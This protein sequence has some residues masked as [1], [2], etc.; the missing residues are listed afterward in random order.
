MDILA[1]HEM[2]RV[3]GQQ[4]GLERVRGILEESI[5][6][7]LNAAIKETVAKITPE[8]T[9]KGRAPIALSMGAPTAVPPET[10]TPLPPLLLTAQFVNE[11]SPP[12]T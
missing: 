2:F 11:I 10:E 12:E 8:L 7:Y 3:L 5:D 9:A 4:M 6:V 1:M